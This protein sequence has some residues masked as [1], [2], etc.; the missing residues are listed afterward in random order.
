MTGVNIMSRDDRLIFLLHNY[1]RERLFP[2]REFDTISKKI[3]VKGEK[4]WKNESDLNYKVCRRNK[5]TLVRLNY[6]KNKKG[7][8]IMKNT[9]Y[10]N[11]RRSITD[12]PLTVIERWLNDDDYEVRQA[13]MNAC[14]TGGYERLSGQ[15]RTSDRYRTL[16][17]R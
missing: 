15:R 1:I 6:R 12:I 17:E 2:D 5:L 16:V 7:C 11:N 13:A 8:K 3:I 4:V 14:Q 9:F 10:K